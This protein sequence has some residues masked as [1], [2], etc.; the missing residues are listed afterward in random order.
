MVVLGLAMMP[1]MISIPQGAATSCY[2]AT[3]DECSQ[4]T[5]TYFANCREAKM[6]PLARDEALADRLWS[7]SCR[8][9][10]L[11]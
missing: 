9:V 11:S 1:F 4:R 8:L 2:V 6:S 10:G 3:S 7:E 5:G